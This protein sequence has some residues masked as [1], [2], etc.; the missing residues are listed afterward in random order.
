MGN[1]ANIFAGTQAA[2]ADGTGLAW[3][4]PTGSTAPTDASTG[5]AAAWKNAGLITEDGLTVKFSEST[6]KIKAYGS[7]VVQ[8][9]LVTDDEFSFDLSFLETNNT[10]M[11]VFHRL[12][13]GSI[14]PGVG[15]GAFS[16]TTGTYTRRLYAFTADLIDGTNHIR[17]YCPSVEVTGKN[18]VKFQNGNEASWGITLT[19]YPNTSG[20]A[21][22]W[23]FV[24]SAL[25]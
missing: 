24:M 9:T 19:A 6:K 25:G 17:A 11:E 12:A 22:Q 5:L 10:S 23:Y 8:R 14:S 2:G 15:T 21:I 16:L 13:L 18:D 4:A 7:T 1:N 20:V 3:F